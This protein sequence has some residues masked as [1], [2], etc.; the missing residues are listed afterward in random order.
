LESYFIKYSLRVIMLNDFPDASLGVVPFNGQGSSEDQKVFLSETLGVQMALA[1]GGST[2]PS[3]SP[4]RDFST[5]LQKSQNNAIAQPVLHFEPSVSFPESTVAAALITHPGYQQLSIFVPF[6]FFSLT[7]M[8][9]GHLWFQWSTR[10]IYPGFRRI[11]F[12]TH[13]DDVFLPTPVQLDQPDFRIN[14]T[15]MCWRWRNG[16]PGWGWCGLE[17]G[18]EGVG[19]FDGLSAFWMGRRGVTLSFKEGVKV[20]I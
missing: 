1:A 4:Q 2:P 18:E 13:V 8:L 14:V 10:S 9:L 12:S 5:S 16:K 20:G 3:P 6:V 19:S 11:M 7:S 15:D 17:D